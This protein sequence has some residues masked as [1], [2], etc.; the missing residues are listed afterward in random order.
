MYFILTRTCWNYNFFSANFLW[1]S[2]FL[3]LLIAQGHGSQEAHEEA[4]TKLFLFKHFPHFP[5]V[6][7]FI[8]RRINLPQLLLIPFALQ[9]LNY[10]RHLGPL[11]T[12]ATILNHFFFTLLSLTFTRTPR[13]AFSV[14]LSRE[15]HFLCYFS[16]QTVRNDMFTKDFCTSFEYKKKK[17]KSAFGTLAMVTKSQGDRK[18]FQF[19]VFFFVYVSRTLSLL[20]RR[21]LFLLSSHTMARVYFQKFAN[22]YA[23]CVKLCVQLVIRAI[24]IDRVYINFILCNLFVRNKNNFS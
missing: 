4:P 9:L 23:L 1:S 16:L 18:L 12:R 21:K 3:V 8:R 5:P 2:L 14:I 22:K 17:K 19:F 11:V 20:I 24:F 6:P 10:S 7:A 13:K 15:F